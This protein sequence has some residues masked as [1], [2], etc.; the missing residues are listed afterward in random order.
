[1]TRVSIK[2]RFETREEKMRSSDA[3]DMWSSRGPDQSS[4]ASKFA[5]AAPKPTEG[6]ELRDPR[7]APQLGTSMVPHESDDFQTTV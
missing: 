5:R 1:M 4:S 3:V 7:G 2:E 6:S